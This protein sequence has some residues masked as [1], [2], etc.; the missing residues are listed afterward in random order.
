MGRDKDAMEITRSSFGRQRILQRTG[1]FEADTVYGLS[2]DE[3]LADFKNR[4]EIND[5]SEL[6]GKI[7]LDAGCGLDG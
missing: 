1:H 7:V 2:A 4:L 3:E 5:M 6:D